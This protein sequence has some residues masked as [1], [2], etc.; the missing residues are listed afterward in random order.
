MTNTNAFNKK[1]TLDD[2]DPYAFKNGF[3]H[4][5]GYE[6][7]NISDQLAERGKARPYRGFT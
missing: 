6:L 4:E 2:F 1:N 3:N 5:H 7:N